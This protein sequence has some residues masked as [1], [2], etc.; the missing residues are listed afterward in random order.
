MP[1]PYQNCLDSFD[2]DRKYLYIS[3]L[4]NEKLVSTSRSSRPK[5][6]PSSGKGQIT[7]LSFASFFFAH[8]LNRRGREGRAV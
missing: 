3:R 8:L 6:T 4:V 2:R 1:P 5:E 7:N